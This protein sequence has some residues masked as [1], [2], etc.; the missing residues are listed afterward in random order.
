MGRLP[1][2]N[3]G[4]IGVY[5]QHEEND[6]EDSALAFLCAA[7][8]E[9]KVYLG[10]IDHNNQSLRGYN[11]RYGKKKEKDRGPEGQLHHRDRDVDTRGDTQRTQ[12]LGRRPV[13]GSEESC[14]KVQDRAWP[15]K[16]REEK[17]LT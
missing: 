4:Y 7:K 10:L 12:M 11:I 14:G 17:I 16:K 15:Q 1:F 9:E 3:I 5:K 13:R 8:E 2:L 6:P